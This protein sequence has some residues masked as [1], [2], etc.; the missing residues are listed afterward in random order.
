LSNR[1]G[2]SL[3]I[4]EEPIQK[5]THPENHTLRGSRMSM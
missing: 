3:A 5:S 1:N 2:A 4:S